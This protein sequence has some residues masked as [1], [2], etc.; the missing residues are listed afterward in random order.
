MLNSSRIAEFTLLGFPLPT[1]IKI[2]VFTL[3]LISYCV[4]LAAN[5][6]IISV[7]R[8]NACLYI[9]MYIFISNF[10]LMEIGCTTVMIPKMLAD[11]LSV[12]SSI[13]LLGCLIQFYLISL[14]GCLANILL[15]MMG[16]DRYLAIC[17]PLRYS[18]IMTHN[19]CYIM[20]VTSWVTSFLMPLLP[21][22]L[23]SKL[24]FCKNKIID[25]FFCDFGPLVKL[26]CSDST[27]AMTCFFGQ[28]WIIILTCFSTTLISYFFIMFTILRIQTH[29]GRQK[30]FSTCASHLT[31]VG[32][33]YGSIIFMY[34]RPSGANAF[35]FDKIV[36]VFYSVVTPLLNPIIYSLRNENI[37]IALKNTIYKR[38][39]SLMKQ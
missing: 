3:V 19:L 26:S 25:H 32:I 2:I 27:I 38:K 9:P 33:F 31:V 12:Q 13:S 17:H 1:N 18:S 24:Y 29:N 30:A 37:K 28:A 6:I 10:S 21:T 11:L 5:I 14:Y 39:M 15:A 4:T 20:T 34:V 7:V 8:Q 36:S 16:Y 35:S 23:V 22:I